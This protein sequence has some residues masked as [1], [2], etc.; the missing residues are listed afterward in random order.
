MSDSEIW[1]AQ[2]DHSLIGVAICGKV[3]LG[4][5][6]EDTRSEVDPFMEIADRTA[7]T[8]TECWKR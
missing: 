3:E 6:G 1:S 2:F 4:R 7:V 8:Y 5:D